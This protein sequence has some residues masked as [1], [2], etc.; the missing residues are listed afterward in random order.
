YMSSE[1]AYEGTFSRLVLVS[2]SGI[3][4]PRPA[5]YYIK[6][7]VA[8]TLKA[9]FVWMPEPARSTGL[10]WVRGTLPWQLLGSSDYSA[11]DG[12]MRETFVKTVTFHVDGQ[13]GR[14]TLPTL[15][16]WG[17]Q[18]T[19]VSRKQMDTL[20]QA[21]DGAGLVVLEGAGH[22]GYLDA[23]PVFN[24]A[25]RHFLETEKHAAEPDQL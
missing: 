19:A 18:D 1:P 25:V 10:Q 22:Y 9:P 16:F 2:P 3:T 6:T 7:A 11:L 20:E 21:I 4:P 5:S 12:V 13:V 14:I 17:D 15:L 23:A 8:K 24:A